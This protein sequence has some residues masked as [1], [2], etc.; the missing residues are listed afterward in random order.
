MEYIVFSSV[1]TIY[2]F[3]LQTSKQWWD[4]ASSPVRANRCLKYYEFGESVVTSKITKYTR[5]VV[6]EPVL[7]ICRFSYYNLFLKELN[8][9]TTSKGYPGC[10]G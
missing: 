7:Q 1:A 9:T 5:N 3:L 10:I 2:L 6:T 4:S 8:S